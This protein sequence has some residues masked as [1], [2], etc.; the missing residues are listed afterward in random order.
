MRKTD[1]QREEKGE[2]VCVGQ[3][4]AVSRPESY[5]VVLVQTRV[6]R[7]INNGDTQSCALGNTGNHKVEPGIVFGLERGSH[8]VRRSPNLKFV[9]LR[10]STL[11]AGKVAIVKLRREDNLPVI[12]R[13][14]AVSWGRFRGHRPKNVSRKKISLS[15]HTHTHTLPVGKYNRRPKQ[16]SF[17]ELSFRTARGGGGKT[18]LFRYEPKAHSKQPIHL[19]F[20]DLWISSSLR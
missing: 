11:H 19:Y 10:P 9:G 18:A 16:L 6:R 1:R 5:H 4:N 15:P 17:T 20:Q 3:N 8:V 7:C 13:E 12:K 14:Y 2:C